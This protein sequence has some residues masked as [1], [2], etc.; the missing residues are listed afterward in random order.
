[1]LLFKTKICVKNC[2]LKSMDKGYVKLQVVIYHAQT[3][4]YIIHLLRRHS[5]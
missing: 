2:I 1:M 3:Y 4:K 5:G